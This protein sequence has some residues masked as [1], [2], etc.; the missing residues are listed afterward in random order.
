MCV[1]VEHFGTSP[2]L[3]DRQQGHSEHGVGRASNPF[4]LTLGRHD[5]ATRGDHNFQ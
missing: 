1:E 3:G 4:A 2:C 5:T